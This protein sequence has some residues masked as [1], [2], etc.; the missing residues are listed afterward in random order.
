MTGHKK[1]KDS[2]LNPGKAR[3]LQD[4]GA[5]SLDEAQKSLLLALTQLEED[6]GR[7]LSD[8]EKNALNSL[9][10][11]LKAHDIDYIKNAVRQMV[12]KPADPN[13]QIDWPDINIKGK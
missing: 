2:L 7:N 9:A 13:R 6:L 10:N 12:T 11:Q 3:W 5:K 8:E 4:K 1:Q